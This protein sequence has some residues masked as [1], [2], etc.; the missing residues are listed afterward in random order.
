MRNYDNLDGV[1]TSFL[2]T[3]QIPTK[4]MIKLTEIIHL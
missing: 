2:K 3:L 4:Y 1:S